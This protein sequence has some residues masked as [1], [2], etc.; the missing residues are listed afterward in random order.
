MTLTAYTFIF[1][2]GPSLDRA[3][4]VHNRDRLLRVGSIRLA[5]WQQRC[6]Y[7]NGSTEQTSWVSGR[8]GPSAGGEEISSGEEANS[9]KQQKAADEAAASRD[10]A[11]RGR[12]A[13]PVA[14]AAES[15]AAPI[16]PRFR[17]PACCMHTMARKP[18]EL[19]DEKSLRD[20]IQVGV[21]QFS[22]QLQP[23]P[24]PCRPPFFH[25]PPSHVS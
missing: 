4:A 19:E 22:M 13:K 25:L 24:I 7:Q 20:S 12:G 9:R 15:L 10:L 1:S 21:P 11:S 2:R 3:R 23:Y 18:P 17:L 5:G 6:R 14:A 8:K 16:S